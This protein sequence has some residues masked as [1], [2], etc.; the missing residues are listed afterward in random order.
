M[1]Y[2]KLHLKDDNLSCKR[3]EENVYIRAMT[4]IIKKLEPQT[5]K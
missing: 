1:F 2:L 5:V 4:I 3:E